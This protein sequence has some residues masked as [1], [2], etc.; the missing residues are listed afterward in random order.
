MAITTDMI[1]DL[2]EKT[3]AGVLDCRKAL[4]EAL[5]DM[6]KAIAIL[7]EQGLAK[8]AKKA[9]RAARDGIVEAYVHPGARLAAIVE[10]NCETDFVART[11]EFKALA[12]DLAM[13]IAAARP[14]YVSKDDVPPELIE[15]ERKTYLAQLAEENKPPQVVENIIAGKLNKLYEQIVLLEQPFIKD[16]TIKVGNLV[17]QHIARLGENI[18]V[19][20]FARFAIGEE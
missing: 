20:R 6:E 8:A 11:P 5:G 10:V 9:E 1:K 4:Q 12:H 15:A 17:A 14:L 16:E 18:V 7:R 2:R 19:H 13:Q 3:G